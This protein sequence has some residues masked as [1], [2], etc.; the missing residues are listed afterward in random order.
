MPRHVCLGGDHEL[1]AHSQR[2]ARDGHVV[3]RGGGGRRMGGGA[4]DESVHLVLRTDPAGD[5]AMDDDRYT[6]TH[7]AQTPMASNVRLLT[8]GVSSKRMRPRDESATR[9]ER[10]RSIDDG[11]VPNADG[12]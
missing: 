7:L 12:A 11:E 1:P 2:R 10:V 5:F 6:A 3:D 8:M 9:V 4:E